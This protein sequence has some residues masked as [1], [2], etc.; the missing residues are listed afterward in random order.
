VTRTEEAVAA[1]DRLLTTQATEARHDS[2]SSASAA[3]QSTQ[4][5]SLSWQ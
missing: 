3:A 2:I 5:I 4:L 1:Q